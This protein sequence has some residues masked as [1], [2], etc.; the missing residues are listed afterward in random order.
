VNEVRNWIADAPIGVKK[1]LKER[2]LYYP[3]NYRIQYPGYKK[4][5]NQKTGKAPAGSDCHLMI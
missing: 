2:L 5:N 3:V 1:D 4:A